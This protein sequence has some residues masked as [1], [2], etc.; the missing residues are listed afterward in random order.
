MHARDVA[1]DGTRRRAR[2]VRRGRGKQESVR[3]L[4]PGVRAGSPAHGLEGALAGD[5]HGRRR[6]G[7]APRSVLQDVE[8][9]ACD[10]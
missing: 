4:P 7:L 2:V 6:A 8:P 3:L 5:V 10:L 9:L 1:Q